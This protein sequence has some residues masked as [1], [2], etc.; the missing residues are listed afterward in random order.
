MYNKAGLVIRSLFST[1]QLLSQTTETGLR[2]L[3]VFSPSVVWT[4]SRYYTKIVTP[5]ASQARAENN[6]QSFVKIENGYDSFILSQKYYIQIVL[7]AMRPHQM[8]SLPLP[9]IIKIVW[10]NVHFWR[11]TA[12]SLLFP[13]SNIF[14]VCWKSFQDEYAVR[15][16]VRLLNRSKV[17]FVVFFLSSC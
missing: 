8:L 12:T 11:K 17:H 6:V 15:P 16:F 9:T 13:L 10:I 7:K 14:S 1:W 3:K 2:Q 5:A 4:R